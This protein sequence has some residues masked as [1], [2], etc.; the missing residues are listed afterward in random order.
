M[1]TILKKILNK[2][3]KLILS[4]ILEIKR[5]CKNN[6][7]KQKVFYYHMKAVVMLL[8]FRD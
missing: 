4:K 3:A 5:I 2:L 7:K 8:I 6:F 1:I